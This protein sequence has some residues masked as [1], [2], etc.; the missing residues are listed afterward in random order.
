MPRPK[1]RIKARLENAFES[2]DQ[3]NKH[4]VKS[5]S[6]NKLRDKVSISVNNK[7]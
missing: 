2:S 1:A 6:L 4:A 7:I 3:E 5:E